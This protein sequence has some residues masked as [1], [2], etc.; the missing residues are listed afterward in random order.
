MKGVE[1]PTPWAEVAHWLAVADNDRLAVLACMASDPPLPEI[2]AFH[3][4]QAVEKLLKGFL[5]FGG[6]NF[7]RT[8]NSVSWALPRSPSSRRSPHS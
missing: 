8:Q 2:A 5:V 7:R 6:I 3:C 4:Q 1:S